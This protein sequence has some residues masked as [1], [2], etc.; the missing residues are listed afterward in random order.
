MLEYSG[1]FDEFDIQHIS[2]VKNS[3][4]NDLKQKAS[5]YRVTRG[6]FH[7]YENPVIRGALSS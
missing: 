7:I 2:R 1:Y 4:A 6:K 3:K 5:G